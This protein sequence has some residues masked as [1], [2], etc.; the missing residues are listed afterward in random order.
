MSTALKGK[1]TL[2]L[3]NETGKQVLELKKVLIQNQANPLIYNGLLA[4]IQ[5]TQYVDAV[6][7]A[8]VDPDCNE[9]RF[10]KILMMFATYTNKEVLQKAFE[11]YRKKLSN[12]IERKGQKHFST[13]VSL[14]KGGITVVKKIGFNL[15]FIRREFRL[16]Q[17]EANKLQKDGFVETYAKLK[18]NAI[19]KDMIEQIE[20]AVR[21]P[22]S[23]SLDISSFYYDEDRGFYNV[24]L[25]GVVS[26][27]ESHLDSPTSSL[28]QLGTYF[29]Q[30]LTMVEKMYHKEI[31]G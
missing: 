28:S 11:D 17:R 31:N 29:D 7:K 27:N 1:K 15:D 3:L 5:P 24:D 21:T 20:K 12:L 25:I 16:T 30:V 10:N 13:A 23:V 22:S 18:V 6:H 26:I 19:V 9:E 14:Q 4:S 2:E 8:L